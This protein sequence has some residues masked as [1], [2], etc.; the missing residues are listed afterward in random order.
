LENGLNVP[1][2]ER[3]AEAI[4]STSAARF[5]KHRFEFVVLPYLLGRIVLILVAASLS[6][7]STVAWPV[8][9]R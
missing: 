3:A 8:N 5:E 4:E 9:A 2:H 6:A 1:A 7:S